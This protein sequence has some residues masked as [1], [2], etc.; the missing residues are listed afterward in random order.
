M[1]RWRK[2]LAELGEEFLEGLRVQEIPGGGR[3][4]PGGYDGQVGDG[5]G[6]QNLFQS[7]AAGKVIGQTG[8]RGQLENLVEP[9]FPQVA[10]DQDYLALIQSVGLGQIG[11]SMVFPSLGLGLVTMMAHGGLPEVESMREE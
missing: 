9:G 6:T 4:G 7:G 8:L 1:M 5:S 10:I 2:L 3:P 11:R